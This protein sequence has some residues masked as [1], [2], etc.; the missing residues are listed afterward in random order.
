M[1]H[2]II[3]INFL[4]KI[5]FHSSNVDPW[6]MCGKLILNTDGQG[7]KF[8]NTAFF[9]DLVVAHATKTTIMQG[10]DKKIAK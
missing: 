7:K 4:R 10:S 2:E 6:K 5:Q 1:E 9:N 3:Q 8:H